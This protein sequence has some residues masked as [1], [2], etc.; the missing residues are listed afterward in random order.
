MSDPL[1]PLLTR[2]YDELGGCWGLAVAACEILGRRLPESPEAALANGQGL[3]E[4][5]EVPARGDLVVMN[6]DAGE[7]SHVG[8]MVDRF[9]ILHASSERGVLLQTLRDAVRFN[10]VRHIVRLEEI[11]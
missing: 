5:V 6:D 9:R 2:T 3:G 8:V 10:P 7:A 11:T 4:V 1:A